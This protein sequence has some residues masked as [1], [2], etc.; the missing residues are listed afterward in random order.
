MKITKALSVRAP[1][2]WFILH[3]GK[4]IENRDWSTY[5]RGT[6]YVHASKWWKQ[7]GVEVDA[8]IA[9][10]IMSGGDHD[11]ARTMKQAKPPFLKSHGGHIVGKVDIVD[12]VDVSNSPW[13]FGDHG[14]VLA[15]PIAFAQPIPCKGAL[16]FFTVPDDVLAKLE[17]VNA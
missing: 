2:W 8:D 5:F 10:R 11:V 6:V 15:N 7:L 4:D 17:E 1:W 14:F 3:A 9:S 16:G 13:F 12:C